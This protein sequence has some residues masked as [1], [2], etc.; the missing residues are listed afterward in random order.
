MFYLTISLVSGY[1]N[2]NVGQARSDHLWCRYFG[3]GW[4][5]AVEIALFGSMAAP[6]SGGM[7][8]SAVI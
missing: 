8:G 2:Y 6:K 7:H 3:N 4:D 5:T 1:L